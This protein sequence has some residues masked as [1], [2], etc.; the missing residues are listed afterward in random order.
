MQHKRKDLPAK[1]GTVLG[2]APG[3]VPA[4][5]SDYSTADPRE[6]PSRHA[7]RSYV[8]GMYMGYKWQCV[9]FARRWLYLNKGYIFDDVA[10]AYEIF[11]LRSV[12]VVRD[13]T[14]LPLRSFRNGS[15]RHPEPGCLL[16]WEEGGE[17]EHTGHVA[18]VTE[19]TPE[20]IRLVEQNVGHRVWPAGQGFSRQIKAKVTEDGEYW[21]ECSFGDAIILGWVI[22]TDEDTHAEEPELLD[23]RLFNL[24]MRE[25]PDRGQAEESWLNVA[26]A[27]EAAYVEMM[28]GH[29]LTSVDADHYKYYCLSETA[30]T[31]LRRATNE[32][33]AL[34]MHATDTVL[35]DENLLARFNIPRSLW[36][37]IQQSWDNRRNQMITG[38]FDFTV[39]ERGLKVYEYN[40]DSAAC[41]MECGKVQ[42]KWAEHFDC[43]VGW[44]PGE[45]LH[46][47]L[48]DAWKKSDVNDVL[49]ILHDDNLEETYHALFMQEAM[50]QAGIRSKIIRGVEGLS[51]DDE[52]NILDADGVRIRWVWKT[53]AW[54]TALDQ[55]R[56]EC[57]DD[58]EKLTNYQPGAKHDGPPRLVDVL[59]RHDVMVYE[60]LWTLIP[61][62][63]A[64]LPVLWSLFPNHE[65]LLESA[66]ELT[67]SLREKGYVSK[68]IA[69]R[70]GHNIAMFEANDTL[71]HE[72]GGRFERQNQMYQQFFK[73]PTVGGYNVQISTFTA[74]GRYAAS[75]ARVDAT[76]VIDHESD[77]MPL[78]IVDD[79]DIL[80]EYAFADGMP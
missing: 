37:K 15:K 20:Y 22:Q 58:E 59:L 9:E 25:L 57:D 47:E 77:N 28:K 39:S 43:G 27:D 74:G 3:N 72:T 32:L 33:H 55:I 62:N 80:R 76:P 48:R 53:W 12:R 17:F 6:L 67:D 68:P 14:H 60:P 79:D 69:G 11:N 31:D 40:C 41:Y 44:D 52:G 36:K 13:N 18:I 56:A 61:S 19:V 35:R 65:Y 50:E 21:L 4:Y 71:V 45:D 2:I 75:C 8:D 24:Q 63:K 49:H 54:E 7:Y 78:R 38:R 23:P 26:N 64:I 73:L 51:W 16:I 1:F 30:H 34:F 42:G 46:A 29:K 5:S 70:M 66:F 10:M